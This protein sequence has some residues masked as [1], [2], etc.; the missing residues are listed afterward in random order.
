MR[1]LR[2]WLALAVPA[3]LV[4]LVVAAVPASATP[5]A[6]APHASGNCEYIKVFPYGVEIKGGGVNKPVTLTAGVGNCFTLHNKRTWDGYTTYEYQNGAG[7]C[8][9]QNAGTIEVG[10]ACK[11]DH[12]NEEFFG[13]PG[14]QSEYGGWLF[15]VVADGPYTYMSSDGCDAGAHVFM[16]PDTAT[17]GCDAWNFPRG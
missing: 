10:A 7:H 2:K 4:A 1:P 8:L 9:W 3:A 16:A 15:S 17:I 12:P 11:A 6:V 14:S 13:I 5:A